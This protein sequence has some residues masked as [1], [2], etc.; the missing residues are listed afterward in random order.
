MKSER[1]KE[2]DNMGW[3]SCNL[4][5]GLNLILMSFY[6]GIILELHKVVKILQKVFVCFYPIFSQ[7][8]MY[9]LINI[10]CNHGCLWKW[11]NTGT[12]LITR[13]QTFFFGFC[14]IFHWILAVMLL[15]FLCVMVRCPSTP[16]PITY[17][18]FHDLD[19][20]KEW[21]IVSFWLVPREWITG[22]EEWK[23]E[24]QKYAIE[25]RMIESL[26]LSSEPGVYFTLTTHLSWR[27]QEPHRTAWL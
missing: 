18:V 26:P 19:S 22:T 23:W 1:S 7:Y 6:F 4:I 16:L 17:F 12:L 24:E 20:L 8:L 2:R 3:F 11:S 27:A 25:N 21:F 13:L 5:N 15:C 14:Q 9:F 10:L